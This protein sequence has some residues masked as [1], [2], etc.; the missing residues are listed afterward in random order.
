MATMEDYATFS[1]YVKQLQYFALL[2]LGVNQNL[3][4]LFF[5]LMVAECF[6]HS[7]DLF[8]GFGYDKPKCVFDLT[9]GCMS[10][11]QTPLRGSC[12][13]QTEFCFHDEC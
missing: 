4:V 9:R 7:G 11:H 3:L 2:T 1:I 5:E 13:T 8:P 12:E 10:E 6:Y